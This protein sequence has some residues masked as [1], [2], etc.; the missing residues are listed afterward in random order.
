MPSSKSDAFSMRSTCTS[1]FISPWA[2]SLQP[3][4]KANGGNSKLSRPPFTKYRG[5][6]VQPDGGSTHVKKSNSCLHLARPYVSYRPSRDRKQLR[7]DLPLLPQ[8]EYLET[9]VDT[10]CGSLYTSFDPDANAATCAV[11]AGSSRFR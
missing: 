2:I 10:I 9:M 1:A 8:K 4:L 5:I 7:L 11:L 3:S 6:C